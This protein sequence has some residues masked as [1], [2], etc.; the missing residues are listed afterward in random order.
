MSAELL[1]FLISGITVGAAYALVG[2]G[3]SI[4]YNASHVINFAQGEFVMIGGMVTVFL[5]GVGVPMPLAIALA[6]VATVVVGVVLEKFA[7]EPARNASVVSLIIIT[8]GASIFLRGSA[9]IIWGQNFRNMPAFSGSDPILISGAAIL[10]QSLWVLGGT[11]IV[12]IFLRWFFS[13]TMT[14]KAMRAS[15][16]NPVAAQLVGINGRYILMLSFALS[17]MIGASAG[18]LIAPITLTYPGVG[19]MLGLKGFCAAILGGLGNPFGAIAAGLIVGI[20]EA[21]TAGYISSAYKDAVAF[22]IILLVLFFMP[23]GLFASKGT[24]RV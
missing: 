11:V 18:I 3:F 8:I 6:I 16:C 24:E 7:V 1:Q 21:M 20:S 4:I 23:N 15:A 9:Q 2:L 12:V 5:I 13:H 19:V 14:G 10:P 17:A 22:L